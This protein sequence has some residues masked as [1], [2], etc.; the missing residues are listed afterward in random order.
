MEPSR[1]LDSESTQAG[2]VPNNKLCP[3]FDWQC[4]NNAQIIL[5]VILLGCFGHEIFH[6]LQEIIFD[7]ESGFT[8]KSCVLS[9]FEKGFL[10]HINN[11]N[12]NIFIQNL[13][14][15]RA[16]L[17]EGHDF[18]VIYQ[19]GNQLDDSMPNLLYPTVYADK[20]V[21]WAKEPFL[22]SVNLKKFR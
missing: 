11:D 2:S 4:I 7:E 16:Q 18:E 1:S 3:L 9:I 10:K 19:G 5:I 22:Y 8:G 21:I 6:E 14:N 13:D 12:L 17:P 20:A 15:V